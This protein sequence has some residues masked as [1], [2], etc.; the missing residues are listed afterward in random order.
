M[1]YF[2]PCSVICIRYISNSYMK[3]Q[4]LMLNL[5]LDNLFNYIRGKYFIIIIWLTHQRMYRHHVRLVVFL[6]CSFLFIT[7]LVPIHTSLTTY[8]CRDP[9]ENPCR[10]RRKSRPKCRIF[11]QLKLYVRTPDRALRHVARDNK[12]LRCFKSDRMINLTAACWRG[13]Y[14]E[15]LIRDSS[16]SNP[17]FYDMLAGEESLRRESEEPDQL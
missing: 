14:G 9:G 10:H 15:S 4:I 12:I 13:T 5:S 16:D 2:S 6:H 3:K 7:S 8:T 17:R 11:T 1:A